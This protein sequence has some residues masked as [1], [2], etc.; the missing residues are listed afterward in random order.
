MKKKPIVKLEE[1]ITET[2]MTEEKFRKASFYTEDKGKQSLQNLCLTFMNKK[3]IWACLH[4][5]SMLIKSKLLE[6]EDLTSIWHAMQK[7]ATLTVIWLL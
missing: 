2:D 3:K 6:R 4:E 7:F 1:K 5:E